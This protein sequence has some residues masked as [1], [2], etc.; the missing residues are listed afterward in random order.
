MDQGGDTEGSSSGELSQT[1][2]ERYGGDMMC[3]CVQKEQ[4]WNQSCVWEETGVCLVFIEGTLRIPIKP[5]R[6]D[7]VPAD[8]IKRA[9]R[10]SLFSFL[11]GINQLLVQI[12]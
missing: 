8:D 2:K 10:F 7:G 5:N 1:R 11:C 4:G 6:V 9:D 12:H 3:K